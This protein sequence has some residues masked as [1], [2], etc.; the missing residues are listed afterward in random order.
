VIKCVERGN[1]L[2]KMKDTREPMDEMTLPIVAGDLLWRCETTLL[3]SI[4]L[5]NWHC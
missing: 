2:I 4:R 5:Q 1:Y 3:C